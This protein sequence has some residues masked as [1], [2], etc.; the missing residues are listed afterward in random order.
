MNA[1]KNT[2]TASDGSLPFV[3]VLRLAFLEMASL[4]SA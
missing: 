2:W 3:F 4:G 1:A